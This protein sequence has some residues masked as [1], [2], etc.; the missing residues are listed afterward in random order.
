MSFGS[1]AKHKPQTS[2]AVCSAQI[3]AETH[4]PMQAAFNSA[5]SH[6][7]WCDAYGTVPCK[8]ILHHR[9]CADRVGA[10]GPHILKLDTRADC[11]GPCLW[12][13]WLPFATPPGLA[14]ALAT[15]L[16]VLAGPLFAIVAGAIAAVLQF[17]GSLFGTQGSASG[18]SVYR[19]AV[20]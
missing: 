20:K 9:H 4:M 8:P 1:A 13:C 2:V 5:C 11:A 18:N 10:W 6:M 12:V 3:P 7:L 14:L 15:L 17:C 19:I 16:A